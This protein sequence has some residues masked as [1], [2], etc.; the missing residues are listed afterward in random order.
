ML[1][2]FNVFAQADRYLILQH[3]H[4]QKELVIKQGEF[5][6]VKTFKG[7]KV[8]GTM[9]VLTEDLIKVKHKVVPLT[10]I[11]SIGKRNGALVQLGSAALSM[12]VNLVFYGLQNSIRNG[13]S[14]AD[15]S[16]TVSIPFLASGFSMILFSRKRKAKRWKYQGQLPGW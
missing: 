12:G 1:I 15:E 4:K 11:Q 13:W 5:V 10:S 7:E 16:Y 2:S 8:K 3:R 9:L 6:V 14:T